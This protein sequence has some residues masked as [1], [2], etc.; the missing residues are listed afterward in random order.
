M[1]QQWYSTA[2]SIL[3]AIVTQIVAAF[4]MG[5]F[6]GLAAVGAAAAL[7]SGDGDVSMFSLFTGG[8]M[9]IVALLFALVALGAYVWYFL[10]ISKFVTLQTNKP[11]ADA[12]AMVRNA[13]IVSFAGMICCFIPVVGGVIAALLNIAAAVMILLGFNSYR[14]SAVLPQV[15][16][17]GAGQLK[18][19]AIL[20]I[21]GAVLSLIP[22]A[23]GI[24]GGICNLVGLIFL[25]MGWNNVSK[26]CP[27][28]RVAGE[29]YV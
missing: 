21:V 11:D 14:K 4:L 5:V 8:G 13:V 22:L 3:W 18:V 25:I 28:P 15:G 29:P 1:E 23:G 12:I 9:G 7:L 16:K 10:Q 2:K 20:A 6:L 17:V 24:L 19:Y 27:A 26:G